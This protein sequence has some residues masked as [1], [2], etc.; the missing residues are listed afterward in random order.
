MDEEEFQQWL[1]D[2]RSRARRNA[3]PVD[4]YQTRW[5]PA[6]LVRDPADP[7]QAWFEVERQA[8]DDAPAPEWDSGE[9]VDSYSA[10]SQVGPGRS[11]MGRVEVWRFPMDDD[12]D[13]RPVRTT[14]PSEA[15]RARANFQGRQTFRVPQ[16]VERSAGERFMFDAWEAQTYGTGFW[17]PFGSPQEVRTETDDAWFGGTPSMH[18]ATREAERSLQAQYAAEDPWYEVGDSWIDPRRYLHGGAALAGT[19]AGA[20]TDPLNLIMPGETAL[21]R[22]G[23]QASL[24]GLQ[25]TGEQL[26]GGSRTRYGA[27]DSAR[28]GIELDRIYRDQGVGDLDRALSALDETPEA[29]QEDFSWGELLL[30]SAFSG[31]MQGGFEFAHWGNLG[32][33][34]RDWV[35]AREAADRQGDDALRRF[36]LENP[37]PP[38]LTDRALRP[39]TAPIVRAFT[40]SRLRALGDS[41][42]DGLA[43]L[44]DGSIDPAAVPVH[45]ALQATPEWL[46]Q[47]VPAVERAALAESPEERAAAY[48]EVT[49][50]LTDAMGRG[51]DPMEFTNAIIAARFR[52]E[53]PDLRAFDTLEAIGRELSTGGLVVDQLGRTAARLAALTERLDP[54]IARL[55]ARRRTYKGALGEARQRLD[56][57]AAAEAEARPPREVGIGEEAFPPRRFVD[58]DERADIDALAQQ[59]AEIRERRRGLSLVQWIIKRGG[60]LDENGDVLH[61]IGGSRARPGLVRR[62]GGR[63]S[64]DLALESWELGYWPDHAERPSI[65]ELIDAIS[66]EVNGRQGRYAVEDREQLDL[67]QQTRAIEDYLERHGIDPTLRDVD[68]LRR[69]IAEKIYEATYAEPAGPPDGMIQSSTSSEVANS[70]TRPSPQ[71]WGARNGQAAGMGGGGA[72]RSPLARVEASITPIHRQTAFRRAARDARRRG[73]GTYITDVIARAYTAVFESQHPLVVQQQALIREIEDAA[74][75]AL[76]LKPSENAALLARLSRDGYS[77]GHLDLVDGVR[78]YRQPDV[79][80]SPS[81]REAI[82]T[83]TGGKEWTPERITRFEAYLVARRGVKAWDRY[84]AGDLPR[85]P[86]AMSRSDLADAIMQAELDHPEFQQGAAILYRFLEAHWQKKRDA[87]LITDEQF[88]AGLKNNEDYVPFQRDMDDSGANPSR[89]GEDGDGAPSQSGGRTNKRRAFQRFRGSDRRILSPLSTIMADVY[90]TSD[91]IARNETYRAFVGLAERAGPVGELFAK[92]IPRPMDRTRIDIVEE[93][94]RAVRAAGGSQA[95]AK[96]LGGQLDAL[97]NGDTSRVI[98]RPGEIVEGNRHVIYVWRDGVR[99]GWELTDPEW[100]A[101]LFK[102]MTGLTQESRDLFVDIIAM[103]TQAIR[104]A[105]TSWPGFQ[106]A[107]I[108]RDSVSA[109]MVTDLGYI[110]GEAIVGAGQTL[111]QGRMAKLYNA[112]GTQGGGMVRSALPRSRAQRDLP[113]LRGRVLRMRNLDPREGAATLWR[114]FEQATELSESASRIRLFARAFQRAKKEGM[115][116]YDAALWAG[117]ES[118]DYLD[119]QRSGSKMLNFRRLALFLNAALQGLD[120]TTRTMSA[121]GDGRALLRPLVNLWKRRGVM[122]GLT[123]AQ[124]YQ[125]GR[126]YKYWVKLALVGTFGLMLRALLADDEDYEY[127]FSDYQKNNYWMIRAGSYFISIPKPF[128]HAVLSNI[129]ERA[130]EANVQNDPLAWG[131]LVDSLGHTYIPPHEITAANLPIQ[132]YANRTA[133]GAPI[134]PEGLEDLDP[135]LQYTATTSQISVDFAQGLSTWAGV[136]VSPAQLDHVFGGVGGEFYRTPARVLDGDAPAMN[137]PDIPVLNRFLREPGRGATPQRVAFNDTVMR[138]S[139]DLSRAAGTLRDLR[140]RGDVPGMQRFLSDRDPFERTYAVLQVGFETEERRLHPMNRA[141]SVVIEI[142]RIRR[143]LSG[144]R[145]LANETLFLPTLTPRQRRDAL[146]ALDD[147][148]SAEMQAALVMSSAPGFANRP[149]MDVEA[150]YERLEA[151]APGVSALLRARLLTGDNKAIDF[152]TMRA[153]WPQAERRLQADGFRADL[154]DLSAMGNADF[155]MATMRAL[156]LEAT[157]GRRRS[158]RERDQLL[159][160]L[161]EEA[162]P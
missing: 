27:E 57:V 9:R 63:A 58:D 2:L 35:R 79:K 111:T 127:G 159:E 86:H 81:F 71:G 75:A 39:L 100:S 18:T 25:N 76:D 83:A 128:E 136:E 131:R 151:I 139:G 105:I 155:G 36:M 16:R 40:R 77:A 150:R 66:D 33:A 42:L 147:V 106:I 144:G 109:W 99:E 67:D 26:S 10:P 137:A 14:P 95:D 140:E 138:S 23:F 30:V 11:A 98:Y 4:Y 7:G 74:G 161:E 41:G 123:E 69:E 48:A 64:D 158:R 108:I 133:T 6:R 34:G 82:E 72:Q 56:E 12:P 52:G 43:R 153:L 160:S 90:A 65:R 29:E 114:G 135:H 94:E 112:I 130:Y 119:F 162:Q 146:E 156:E 143:E 87:G 49:L 51:E 78:P 141:R 22:V 31:A 61:S 97:L 88:Q 59:A 157:G 92:K 120:R 62:Q 53:L 70:N 126:A 104:T 132:L 32:R 96:A 80:A 24:G 148:S 85:P 152:E 28:L 46:R 101:D 73:V 15:Q 154:S 129:F 47:T 54:A 103:P 142:G 116:D 44:D 5:G 13:A 45:D 91:R 1:T 125:V 84:N 55:R 89:G 60:I 50:R 102:A 149:M 124:R 93:A 145:A 117:F 107:N 113:A 115:S 68:R 19:F 134:V 38:T 3:R 121:E 122:D 21:G 20:M 118:R 37:A 8:G 110:P 17:T